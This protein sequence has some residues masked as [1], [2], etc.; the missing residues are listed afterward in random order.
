MPWGMYQGSCQPSGTTTSTF[1]KRGDVPGKEI[2]LRWQSAQKEEMCEGKPGQSN[3]LGCNSF[4]FP[5]TKHRNP[6]TSCSCPVTT[7]LLLPTAKPRRSVWH[8]IPLSL[9]SEAL[10]FTFSLFLFWTIPFK[11]TQVHTSAAAAAAGSLLERQNPGPHSR[12]LNQN[13][14]FN[15]ILE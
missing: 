14:P 3:P 8:S 9:S 4:I 15:R 1:T 6:T 10:S 7:P 12:S 11:R 2:G 13:L 5:T